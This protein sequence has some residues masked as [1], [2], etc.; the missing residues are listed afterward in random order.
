MRTLRLVVEFDGANFHGWQMQKDLRTVQGEMTAALQ[1]VLQH[2]VHLVAAGRTDAGCHALA[3]AASFKTARPLPAGNL[4]GA[5]NS[6]TGADIRVHALEEAP[7]R[8]NAR[9]SAGW[10]DYTYLLMRGPSALLRHRAYHPV[11]W[12]QM[13]PMIE[14]ASLLTGDKNCIGL[15]NKSADN[16]QPICRILQAG[17]GEWSGGL[18][19]RIRANHFLYR[20][21]RTVVGTC[22]EIGRGRWGSDRMAELLSGGDRRLAGPPVPADGLYFTGVGYNPLWDVAASPPVT[23]WWGETRMLEMFTY[24]PGTPLPSAG[25]RDTMMFDV[26]GEG[27]KEPDLKPPDLKPPDLKPPDLKQEERS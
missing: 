14:A 19:F 18:I 11:V 13:G 1:F 22:L 15:S 10:R 7:E 8:F 12:P 24:E 25:R 17:W 4:L 16:R 26:E 21:V 20:M 9:W 23:P 6:L 27:L 3:H 2:P 5:V